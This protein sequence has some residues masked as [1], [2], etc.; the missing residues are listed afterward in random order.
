MKKRL[1]ADLIS[2]AH[3]VLKLKGKEDVIRLHAEAGALFEKLSVLKFA[4]ENFEGDL[5]T[6]GSDSS[7]WY[8]RY[9]IQ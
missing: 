4:N 2:I 8:A 3:R 1:E 5:P 7:F 9:C 6:I